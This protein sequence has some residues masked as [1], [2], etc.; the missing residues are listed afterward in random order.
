MIAEEC[1]RLG[2]RVSIHVKVDTGMG[3]LGIPHTELQPFLE[4]IRSFESLDLGGLISHLSSADD[5]DRSFT[6]PDPKFQAS[7]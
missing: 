5:P 4:K 3:R 6:D 7:D 2:K 1:T